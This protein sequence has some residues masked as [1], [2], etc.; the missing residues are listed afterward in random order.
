MHVSS[1]NVKNID[2]IRVIITNNTIKIRLPIGTSVAVNK[3]VKQMA[4]IAAIIE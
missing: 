3:I 4:I 2:G 1:N